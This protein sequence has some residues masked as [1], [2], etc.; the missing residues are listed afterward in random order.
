MIQNTFLKSSLKKVRGF[1]LIVLLVVISILGL[2]LA[3]S[4]YG[5]QEARRASLD[6][7]RKADIEQIRGALE[8]Y[9]ADCGEYPQNLGTT[10]VGNGDSGCPISNIYLSTVPTDP[11]YPDRSY[12]YSQTSQ[13]YII[14]AA[15]EQPPSPSMDVAGCGNCGANCNYKAINP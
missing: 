4:V 15:L 6:S 9:K 11:N 10:I 2:I 12:Y 3:L 13:S 7:K 14:C 8:M 5:M 1:T